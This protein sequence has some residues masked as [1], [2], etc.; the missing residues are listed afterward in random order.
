MLSA[1]GR[2]LRSDRVGYE[3]HEGMGMD[4]ET[5]TMDEMVFLAIMEIIV[6]ALCIITYFIHNMKNREAKL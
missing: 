5:M 6:I 4:V 3:L 2:V 1:V